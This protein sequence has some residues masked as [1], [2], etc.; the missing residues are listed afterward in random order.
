[1]QK[2]FNR[3]LVPVDFSGRSKKAI[4]KAIDLA[5]QYN[6]SIHLLHVTP[7]DYGN[8]SVATYPANSMLAPDNKAELEFKL[9]G[10]CITEVAS[11]GSTIDISYSVVQ[12]AWNESVI[13]FANTLGFDLILI[14]QPESAMRNRKMLLDPNIIASKTN[15][16]V[17]T[18]PTNRS[19]TKLYS[20]VVPVTD[21]LP[22]RK[23]MYG[24]YIA[25]NYNSIIK[26][27]GIENPDTK[28]KVM[29]YMMKAHKLISDNCG[30]KV[31]LEKLSGMNV[32]D[33]VT[34]YVHDKPTDLVILNPGTQTRMPGFFSGLLGNIIQKYA[35]PPILTVNPL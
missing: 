2:L 6:C 22:V 23:L 29:H 33:A 10:L 26:L 4:E 35:A 12:G 24:V 30:V 28:N 16:P 17:I 25:T 27:L 34:R 14:N 9:A 3:L 18:V 15:A 32:A 5:K 1:M 20:I 19:I 7:P 31:E 11:C 21:F 8:W 13:D